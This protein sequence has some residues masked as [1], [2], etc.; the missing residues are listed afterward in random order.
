M[1]TIS[2]HWIQLRFNHKLMAKVKF[3]VKAKDRDTQK[4]FPASAEFVEVTDAF[5]KRIKAL[6]EKDKN[7]AKSFE[8]EVVKP[9]ATKGKKADDA[10]VEDK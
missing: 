5:A 1:V 10:P 3:N 2:T 6:M 4:V 9:K 7:H 8:F